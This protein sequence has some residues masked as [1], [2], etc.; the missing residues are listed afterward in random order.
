MEFYEIDFLPV[1]SPKSGD[2]IT[3]RY[4]D[5]DSSPVIHVV[6]GGFQVT[7]ESVIN[8]IRKY[9]GSDASIDHMVLTHPDNDHAGGL[10]EILSELDVKNLW[11]LRPWDYSKEILPRF[12][13]FTNEENLS[14]RLK[15][16]YKN[17]KVLEDIANEKGV[18]IHSPFAGQKIGLFTVLAPSKD[19]YL[20]LVVNSE[21]TPDVKEERAVANES[22]GL[23][24]SFADKL[25]L[26]ASEWGEEIF[27]DE[28][29]SCENEMSVVQAGVLCDKKI[30]LTGDAGVRS[31]EEA[32]NN[33]HFSGMSLQEFNLVQVPHHGSRRNVNSKILDQLLG[34]KKGFFEAGETHF[35]AVISASE[36]DEK[37]PRKSVIR[38]FHHRGAKVLTTE[39]NQIQAKFRA[40]AREGWGPATAV[41][42]PEE[43]EQI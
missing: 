2:A 25:R 1:N 27:S 30:L 33:I 24:K 18:P 29:T 42:Y 23:L 22:Y 31:L 21:K 32:I 41:P 17:I 11:M 15:E 37:H 40:P 13:R 8:H 36:E 9:Y 20:D 26:I 4:K 16:K 6:D 43:Q 7:G 38:A 12:S 10:R 14:K 39:K 5:Y 19:L 35:T 28:E 3:L 34:K